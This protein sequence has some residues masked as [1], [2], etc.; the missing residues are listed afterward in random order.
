MKFKLTKKTIIILISLLLILVIGRVLKVNGYI[1]KHLVYNSLIKTGVLKYCYSASIDMLE[2]FQQEGFDYEKK[3]KEVVNS[4]LAKLQDKDIPISTA[5]KIPTVTHKI[6]FTSDL[7]PIALNDFYHE[8]LKSYYHSLNS[9]NNDWQH[10]IWTNNLSLFPD[11]IKNI[12][13]VKIRHVQEFKDHPSYVNLSDLLTKG[14]L[15]RP[16]FAEAADLL[17]LMAVQKFG[18]IYSDMDYE[19]YNPEALFSLIQK[20]DYFAAREIPNKYSYYGNAFFA[21]K[22]NHPIINDALARSFKY[23]VVDINDSSAPLYLRY[24]C[25]QYDKLYFSGPPLMTISYFSK[26]NIEGNDD[27]ILPPWMIFNLNF[28]RM[29]NNQSL[30][31][32]KKKECDYTAISKKDFAKNNSDLD[33]LLSAYV[34]NITMQDWNKYYVLTDKDGNKFHY[35]DDEQNIYYNLKDR[36]Q[37]PVIGA[38]M[39]CGSW[40]FGGKVFR[41]KYYLNW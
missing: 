34:D 20:F 1:T 35:N 32:V 2:I 21:A 29:K 25:N 31:D 33:Q 37:Y 38:D 11:E 15:K 41:K 40:T 17:R 16:Y 7:S 4:S 23:Y 13:N 22:P 26:N 36:K 30:T 14:N 24:P 27:V 8:V 5:P 39:F 28:A 18:G 12:K 19:V 6:Y 10:N 3:N 9:I